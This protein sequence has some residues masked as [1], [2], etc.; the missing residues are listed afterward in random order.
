MLTRNYL[1]TQLHLWK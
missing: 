1:G